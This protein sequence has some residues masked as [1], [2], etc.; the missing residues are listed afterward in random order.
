M[1]GYT[2]KKVHIW[3]KCTMLITQDQSQVLTIISYEQWN[4]DTFVSGSSIVFDGTNA[5]PSLLAV[6]LKDTADL[7]GEASRFK[8]CKTRYV[9]FMITKSTLILYAHCPSQLMSSLTQSSLHVHCLHESMDQF[10][11]VATVSKR[12][13]YYEFLKDSFK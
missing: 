12:K 2:I 7:R 13:L 1:C 8:V 6:D 9:H 10:L 4:N 5:V 11:P 3:N